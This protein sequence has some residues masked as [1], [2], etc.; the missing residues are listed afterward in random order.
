MDKPAPPQ[1]PIRHCR[2]HGFTQPRLK[3]HSLSPASFYY[4]PIISPKDASESRRLITHSQ[5]LDDVA[6]GSS[7]VVPRGTTSGRETLFLFSSRRVRKKNVEKKNCS[8]KDYAEW[9]S[10]SLSRCWV[11]SS[12]SDE[13]SGRTGTVRW[14][15]F[16]PLWNWLMFQEMPYSLRGNELSFQRAFII[17]MIKDVIVKVLSAQS[18]LEKRLQGYFSRRNFAVPRRFPSLK[19]IKK[20]IPFGEDELTQLGLI[21]I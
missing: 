11:K 12:P 16:G 10:R 14:G 3:Y 4:G 1:P 17:L 19:W 15:D 20:G 18:E 5:M 8:R 7:K 6:T 2:H 21:T 13:F 9:F